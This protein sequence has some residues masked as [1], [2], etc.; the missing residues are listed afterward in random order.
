[1][2]NDNGT[3]SFSSIR[4]PQSTLHTLAHDVYRYAPDLGEVNKCTSLTYCTR[5]GSGKEVEWVLS[6]YRETVRGVA[7]S[8]DKYIA[9]YSNNN[10]TKI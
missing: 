7:R 1:M 4:A 9:I 8:N 6:L 5:V 3:R 10:R 2:E